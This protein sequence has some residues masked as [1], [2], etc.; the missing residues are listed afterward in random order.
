MEENTP[1]PFKFPG[2]EA[3]KPP[4]KKSG[5]SLFKK[6]EP[7]KEEG[8]SPEVLQA[9]NAVDARV[10]ILEGRHNDLIRKTQLIDKNFLDERK[11]F[12]KETK[13]ISLDILELKRNINEISNKIDTIIS[14]LVTFARK[15]ELDTLSKYIDLWEPV[16]FAT[17]TEVE[18]MI[19]EKIG[20]KEG[21]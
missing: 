2:E 13:L 8:Q 1:V 9:I 18:K 3:E 16:N 21:E 14:E 6:K 12:L 20:N 7:E 15:D 11:R 10:K 19:E 17:K 5:F 4:E